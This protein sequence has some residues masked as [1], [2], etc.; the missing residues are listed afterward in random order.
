MKQFMFSAVI[1]LSLLLSACTS[2]VPPAST[3]QSTQAPVVATNAPAEPS[4]GSADAS[5]DQWVNTVASSDPIELR[6]VHYADPEST[7]EH[8][9][10]MLARVENEWKKRYPNGKVT[11]EYVGW[12]DIDQ[13]TAGYVMANDPV[14]VVFNWGG[15]TANLCQQGFVLPIKQMMPKWWMDSRRPE[16]LQS[17]AN[18]LCPDGTLVM[19]GSSYETQGIIIR[20]DLMKASGVDAA[21][22]ATYEGFLAGLKKIAAQPG[23]E[24]PYALFLGADYSSMDTVNPFFFGN[25]LTFGDFREDGSEKDAWIESAT[26]VKA[27]MDYT[28]PAAQSWQYTEAEQGFATN[29]FAAMSHGNWYYSLGKS[30]DPDGKVFN[31]NNV[32]V[33]PYPYGPHSPDKSPF[34][35][36]S[37]TGLYLMKTSAEAHHQAAADL[38]AIFS[39][40][41]SV[42]IGNDGNNPPGT[43]WTFDTRLKLVSDPN[44]SWWWDCWKEVFKARPFATKGFIARDQITGAAYPLLVS[45]FRGEITPDQLYDKAR[46]ASLPL[47]QEA[48]K[49]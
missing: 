32:T 41:K 8:N 35:T 16:I 46:T 17:P 31:A 37:L 5:Y 43:D 40:S 21:S 13:K 1:V 6:V 42:F 4:V 2:A 49:K 11:W 48:Q 20:K 12:G 29:Q 23:F 7:M 34:Y 39:D 33:L 3:S 22:M 26:I 24:K 15:A 30:Y 18:D 36:F 14:D 25:G 28:L 9:K 38:M 45:M 47:I 44:I 19:A 10:E 27:V